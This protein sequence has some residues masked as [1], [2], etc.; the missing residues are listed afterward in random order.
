MSREI[1]GRIRMVV[2]D[3][4]TRCAAECPHRDGGYGQCT[5]FDKPLVLDLGHGA[6]DRCPACIA[7][8]QA[9]ASAEGVADML[10]D[11]LHEVEQ[12]ARDM[13]DQLNECAHLLGC[14]RG[15][16]VRSLEA[17]AVRERD[18]ARAHAEERTAKVR[19]LARC[20]AA[21]EA[22]ARAHAAKLERVR[23]V[24]TADD[25][26][27]VRAEALRIIDEKEGGM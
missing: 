9:A 14:E 11:D 21:S 20:A 13:A 1:N 2:S 4:G 27:D 22:R 18:E 6:Y 23:E 17:Q 16:I 7:A 8:E 19:D 15:D 5:A 10:R 24:V 12:D 26:D 3:D 25:Y